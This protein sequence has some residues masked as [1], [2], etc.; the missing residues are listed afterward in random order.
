MNYVIVALAVF[1]LVRLLQ[2]WVDAP[3]WLWQL[4]TPAAAA[5]VL[6]PWSGGWEHWYSPLAVGGLVAFLQ[7]GENLLIAKADES[8]SA[9]MRRR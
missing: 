9:I 3:S 1:W 7:M 8:V 4:V 2:T 6:L 5:L